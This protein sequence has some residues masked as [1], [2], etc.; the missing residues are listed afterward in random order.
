MQR[1]GKELSAVVAPIDRVLVLTKNQSS[2]TCKSG[3]DFKSCTG[4]CDLAVDEED[5]VT[6][7]V[8]PGDGK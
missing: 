1:S 2:T 4:F 8:I 6:V 5:D 3:P 7:C